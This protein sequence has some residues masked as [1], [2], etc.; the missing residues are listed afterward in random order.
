MIVDPGL[1]RKLGMRAGASVLLVNA[2]AGYAAALREVATGVAIEVAGAAAGDATAAA[3]ADA[4]SSPG[5]APAC[6]PLARPSGPMRGSR[7]AR[8]AGQTSRQRLH[9]LHAA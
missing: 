1:P 6:N 9:P 7:V 3:A 4:A 2:P 8:H 5:V